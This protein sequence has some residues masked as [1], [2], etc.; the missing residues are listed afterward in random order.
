LR[1]EI[2]VPDMFQDHRLGDDP[3]GVAHEIFE[4][5]ARGLQRNLSAPRSSGES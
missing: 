4:E 3:A 5:R 2:V 1:I